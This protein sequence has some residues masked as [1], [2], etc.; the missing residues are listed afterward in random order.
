[1]DQ[2]IYSLAFAVCQKENFFHKYLFSNKCLTD[3][4]SSLAINTTKTIHE[5]LII[6]K[7][8]PEIL[9]ISKTTS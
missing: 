3:Q 4:D 9:I 7:T 2:P 8:L 1:M 6:A 5:L